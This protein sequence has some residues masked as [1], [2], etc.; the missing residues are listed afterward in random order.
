MTQAT[1]DPLLT[2]SLQVLGTTSYFG[3]IIAGRFNQSIPND[4]LRFMKEIV[5][6]RCPIQ[7]GPVLPSWNLALTVGMGALLTPDSNLAHTVTVR[8]IMFSGWLRTALLAL[9]FW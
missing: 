1:N 5:S 7:G 4:T 8:F 2:R 3:S 6:N 9:V